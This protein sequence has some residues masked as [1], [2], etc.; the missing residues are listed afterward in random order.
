MSGMTMKDLARYHGA[1]SLFSPI[2]EEKTLELLKEKPKTINDFYEILEK[3]ANPF[4]LE[5]AKRMISEKDE[6][7]IKFVNLNIKV[8]SYDELYKEFYNYYLKRFIE[9]K[10]VKTLGDL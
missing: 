1:V 6:D 7:D 2:V 5:V 10:E 3:D 9:K 4:I 8:S